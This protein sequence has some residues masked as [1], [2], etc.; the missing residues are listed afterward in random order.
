MEHEA[1]LDC[2]LVAD[3][4]DLGA[5]VKL[6]RVFFDAAEFEDVAVIG[7]EDCCKPAAELGRSA[8]EFA[9][10]SGG[11]GCFDL[12]ADEVEVLRHELGEA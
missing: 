11:V 5:F 8:G 3:A 12:K 2:R 7:F 6:D 9:A 4:D 10:D 1:D